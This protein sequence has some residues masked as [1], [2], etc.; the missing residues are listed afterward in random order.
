MN[1]PAPEWTEYVGVAVVLFIFLALWIG[2]DPGWPAV[3]TW[4]D[5]A[6]APAWVQAVGSIVGILV[7]VGVAAHQSSQQRADRIEAD[8]QRL[9][10]MFAAPIALGQRVTSELQSLYDGKRVE[11]TK[12]VMNALGA[13]SRND[14]QLEE[15]MKRLH[16]DVWMLDPMKLP[17]V[18]SINATRELIEA[19]DSA[20]SLYPALTFEPLLAIENVAKA[21]V[22]RA[23][24][25]KT[26][27]AAEKALEDLTEELVLLSRS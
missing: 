7:A 14:K 12:I 15:R 27:D 5:G 16:R 8:A 25:K 18:R 13:P 26:I 10:E 9:A 24:F 19:V 22:V 1:K 17:S 6:N 2:I 20:N 3:R 4:L 23:S 21:Q 11:G